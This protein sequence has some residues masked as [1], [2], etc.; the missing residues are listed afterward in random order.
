M[1]L[2]DEPWIPI[3]RRD[4]RRDWIS[5]LQLSDPDV[6]AFDADRPDF[7]GA[8]AQFAIGLLQTTT[9]MDSPMAWRKWLLSPPD[10]ATLAEW[11]RPVQAA[12][13]F[14]GDG[15]RFMQD[16]SLTP[17]AG[18]VNDISALL[19]ETPGEN[20]LKHN[21][22]LFIKRGQVEGLCPHCA[23]AALLCLQINAPA[24]GAGHRTG[25]R[26]GGPLTT[27]LLGQNSTCLWQDLWLNVRERSRFLD[28][29]GDQNKTAPHFTFPWLADIASIQK[30]G[31]E[32]AP[33]QVHPFH[34]FWAMPRRIRLDLNELEPGDCDLCGR[35]SSGLIRRYVTKPNGL[36]YKGPWNHP[37]SPHYENKG[38]WLPVHPQPGGIGYRHWLPLV[39][40]L[41]SDK[42]KLRPALGIAQS[43]G[44]AQSQVPLRL[45]ASGF[46][47]DNMKARCWYE[48]TLPLYGLPG[49]DRDTLDQLAAEVKFWLAGADLAAF[50]LRSAVKD[51]WFGADARGDFSMVD[52]SF[53]HRTEVG[54]Y[55]HLQATI[56]VL[57]AGGED[58]PLPIRSA[59]QQELRRVCLGLFDQEFVGAG[60]VERQ[61][62]RRIALAHRQLRR[63]L[64]GPKFRQV[65]GLPV[66]ETDKAKAKT[67]RQAKS[68]DGVEAPV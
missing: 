5:P 21:G 18:S 56:E 40:G 52:A 53:W 28:D 38:D 15:A 32:T 68:P 58:D 46:D 63:N 20:T 48:A 35:S 14:E 1:N 54:F 30:E 44:M 42:K 47:M 41:N 37:L 22:D 31:G 13:A 51:A 49:C 61:S 6:L 12:F 9:P 10:A 3:C 43:P 67:K 23:A 45:W 19:I 29:A 50:F 60:Q 4:N 57:R 59:W 34:V 24:G 17:E 62:P 2:L 16:F 33:I 64:D 26:G 36:N 25:L 39:I 7:N 11:F 65:L 55:T 66:P 27:L 8:L